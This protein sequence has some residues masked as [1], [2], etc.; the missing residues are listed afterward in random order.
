MN[1]L[2]LLLLQTL[3]QGLMEGTK[4]KKEG[5]EREPLNMTVMLE[6]SVSWLKVSATCMRLRCWKKKWWAELN[7][8]DST[9]W[10][11]W[12][13]EKTHYTQ[14]RQY[15]DINLLVYGAFCWWTS[16]SHNALSLRNRRDTH[17]NKILEQIPDFERPNIT[18]TLEQYITFSCQV[19]S[20][21]VICFVW[22]VLL[23]W[24]CM[25]WPLTSTRRNWGINEGTLPLTDTW[26]FQ[27]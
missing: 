2:P 13:S 1:L 16:F 20:L 8:P 9:D 3:L 22:T 25:M 27:P 7:T 14:N 21:T 4:H 18:K 11:Y 6:Q 5:E 10:S 23:P 15:A 24:S 17:S 26:L 12:R 19:L